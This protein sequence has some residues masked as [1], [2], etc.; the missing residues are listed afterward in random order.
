MYINSW[1]Q[2]P[3]FILAST[4][5]FC[6]VLKTIQFKIV[7]CFRIALYG[8]KMLVG[9]L[10]RECQYINTSHIIPQSCKHCFVDIIFFVKCLT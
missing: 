3:V 5:L 7:L 8:G 4:S 2:H 9:N 10:C 6:M 1:F